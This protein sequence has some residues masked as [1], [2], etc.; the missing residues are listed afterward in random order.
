MCQANTNFVLKQGF[1]FSTKK[2]FMFFPHTTVQVSGSHQHALEFISTVGC[3]VSLTALTCTI[4]VTLT[5]WRKL[6]SVRTKVLLHLC[7]FLAGSCVL[8]IIADRARESEVCTE[9]CQVAQ[10]SIK[11]A[12]SDFWVTIPFYFNRLE[13]HHYQSNRKSNVSGVLEKDES[14]K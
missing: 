13:Q 1:L 3:S 5:F 12:R 6:V 11:V 7:F 4:L 10:S 2:T 8:V 14:F 9:R